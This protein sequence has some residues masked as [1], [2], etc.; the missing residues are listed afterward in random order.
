MTPEQW[1]FLRKIIYLVAIAVLLGLLSWLGRPSTRGT[2]KHEG[3]SGGVLAKIRDDPENPLSQAQLGE[4]DPTSETIR[5]CTFGLRSVAAN[6]LWQKAHDYKMKKDWTNLSAT[7]EQITK[8]QP[9]FVSVWRF[10]GWNL[11]YNVSVEFDDFRQRYRWVIRGI[12]FLR[13]GIRY[14]QYEPRLVWDIGWFTSQK[15][16]RADESKQFRRLFRKDD[17]F[18]D[19]LPFQVLG[20]DPR[21]NWLV[22]KQWFLEAEILVDVHGAPITGMSP[23]IFRSDAPMCQMNYAEDLE[24]DGIPQCTFGPVARREWRTA[25]E[26]WDQFGSI[27]I[28]TAFELD[29]HLNDLDGAGGKPGRINLEKRLQQLVQA[30]DALEPDLRKKIREDKRAN[31][32]SDEQRRAQETKL[33]ERTPEQH[34]LFDEAERAIEVSHEELADWIARSQPAKAAEARKLAEQATEAE[35][36]AAIV[37]RYRRIVNFEYWR[38]RARME[39]IEETADARKLSYQAGQAIFAEGDLVAARDLYRRASAAW[40]KVIEICAQKKKAEDP[41]Q[42]KDELSALIADETFVADVRLMIGQYLQVL[43]K[44]SELFP[45]DFELQ[46]F[47]R[48]KVGN[49]PEAR[50]ARK[51]ISQGETAFAE[52]DPAA[53]RDFYHRGFAEWRKVLDQFPSLVLMSDRTTGAELSEVIDDYGK[54]VGQLDELFPANFVLQD[55][56][57]AQVTRA[58]E[59]LAARRFISQGDKAL[60]ENDLP[61]AREAYDLALAEWRKVLDKFPT[62]IL[63]SD[64]TTGTELLEV[65]NGYGRILKRLQEPFPKD[66]ILRDVVDKFKQK[67]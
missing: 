56:V 54:I 48:A 26:E 63:M 13:K 57:H 27:P 28:P 9:N 65:I 37:R 47:I 10:Q 43:D 25:A 4:I 62:L 67:R 31:V 30:L 23:M 22:G 38:H 2:Q 64:R 51:F 11:S 3:S 60:A 59:T 46:D 7:L 32:L 16:G 35:Q 33:E 41:K 19:G 29:I 14:N 45:E 15:V 42:V 50:A 8:L 58:D 17:D 44:F 6:I 40:R 61:A 66:F 18:H 36:S 12:D 39:Q 55:F 53:A 34:L 49:T 20:R 52:G 21:D 24:K 5:L 1:A